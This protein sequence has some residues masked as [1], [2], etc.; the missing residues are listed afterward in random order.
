[1]SCY[2]A[3]TTQEIGFLNQGG[4]ADFVM[5]PHERLVVASLLIPSYS[6][7]FSFGNAGRYV[8]V[9]P[10]TVDLEMACMLPCS[11][12]TAY[13]AIKKAKTGPNDVLV[14]IGM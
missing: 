8:V 2:L 13:S 7:L 3:G 9:L 1:M 4:Y 12:L 5:V 11:G 6:R 10:S 14:I